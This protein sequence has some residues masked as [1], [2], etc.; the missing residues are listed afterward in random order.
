MHYQ[1]A[2]PS[3]LEPAKPQAKSGSDADDASTTAGSVATKLAEAWKQRVQTATRNPGLL[4]RENAL[5]MRQSPRW[6]QFFAGLMVVIGGGLL[7][8][9][10]FVRID[11]I[12]TATG[13]LQSKTG[14]AEVKTP[15]GGKVAE[16]LIRNGDVVRQGQPLVR[17]DTAIAREQ[18]VTSQQL[19]SLEQQ[20][21]A[22]QLASL[23]A[24]A[25]VIDQ[26]LTT[27]RR[28]TKEY[29]KL[30]AS[31]GMGGLDALK[32]QDSLFDLISRRKVLD[33]DRQKIQ[34]EAEKKIR[35]LQARIEQLQVQLNYQN[36]LAPVGG[37]AFEVKA[38]PAGVIQG[39]ETMLTIIP[40][41][42]LS[43]EVFV[44]NKDIGF[45]KVGQSAKVRV[46]AFP[47]TRYGE[48]KGTVALVGADALPPDS[49]NNSYRFPVRITLEKPWLE[50]GG[51]RIPL[52][53]GMAITSNL[54]IREKRLIS[55]VS[56]FFAGQLDSLKAL[57]Q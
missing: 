32:Q 48:L 10:Y 7:A 12:V 5:V 3:V 57:R 47:S 56:D 21:L 40:T 28:I 33:Q 42:G 43:A 25:V 23:D 4:N 16:V 37:V 31:G 27:Q 14:K 1:R 49:T 24:Q 38:R 19:I 36:V 2:A 22:R 46:D 54:R 15:A 18:L 41:T 29:A 55:L 39:G 45:I 35:E 8:T 26:R 44:P 6:L 9:G 52:R 13:Q 20:G 17:F 51:I 53:S 30:A 50:A 11:E 34:I